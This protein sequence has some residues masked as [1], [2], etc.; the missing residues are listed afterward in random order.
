VITFS[1]PIVGVLLVFSF[2]V[3]RRRSHFSL[4]TAEGLWRF[5]P[6]WLV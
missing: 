4:P 5:S 6:G 1:V 3:S 2:L